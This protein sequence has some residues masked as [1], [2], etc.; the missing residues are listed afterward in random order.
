MKPKKY[1]L[2]HTGIMTMIASFTSM[3]A[4]RLC[5]NLINKPMKKHIK[6]FTFLSLLLFISCNED[7]FLKEDPKAA[8]YAT[9]IYDTYTGFRSSMNS[10]YSQMRRING[11]SVRTWAQLWQQNTDNVMTRTHSINQFAD[12]T[13]TFSIAK[14]C[15]NWLYIIVNTSNMIIYR[16]EN[17]ASVNWEGTNEE[18]NN[19]KRKIIIG[20][21]RAAR[22][23]AYRLLI[24]AFGPVPLS[25]AEITGSNYSN[26]WERDPIGVIKAQMKEDL[27]IAVENLDM[28][29]ETQIY[30]NQAFARHYLGELYLSLGEF[31]KAIEVLKP[32]CESKDYSLVNSRFGRTAEREDGNYFMD[33]FR[34]PY[35]KDGNTESIFVFANGV[36]DLFPGYFKTY[37][38]TAYTGDYRDFARNNKTEEEYTLWGGKSRGRCHNT[39]FSMFNEEDYNRY[40]KFKDLDE[41]GMVDPLRNPYLI[42]YWLWEHNDGRDNFMYENEDIRGQHTSVRRFF[43]YD[44]TKDGEISAKSISLD[45]AIPRHEDPYQD[46]YPDSDIFVG[47]T[48]YTFFLFQPSAQGYLAWFKKHLY[49]YT[50]KWEAELGYSTDNVFVENCTQ[51]IVHLRLAD[52]YLLLAEAYMMNGSNN[53]AAT[54]INKVRERAGASMISADKLSLDFVLDE[55]SR[56]LVTE[57]LRKI[58]LLRTGKFIERTNLYNPLSMGYVKDYHKLAPFPQATIDANKD[59]AMDQNLGYGGSTTCDFTPAGYPDE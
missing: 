13:P 36:G 50:R 14:D 8:L 4:I 51:T 30:I 5:G 53:D 25:A 49:T 15:Y 40:K 34:N 19:K 57:E 1:T 29:G 45:E 44:W 27:L 23:W 18:E 37:V 55:R 7:T 38:K 43:A 17:D 24:Y 3:L 52:S 46:K 58:T 11:E 32:L 2:S 39:P 12:Y 47:D 41:E 33:M 56:E 54:W 22:A 31:D 26:A 42:K 35:R 28:I 20:E 48:V 59:K 9:N 6:I 21:A 10:V 16:A